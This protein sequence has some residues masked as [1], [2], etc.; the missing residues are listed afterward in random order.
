VPLLAG[1][2]L[3]LYAGKMG[4]KVTGISPQAMEALVCHRWMGNV[5]ELE[6][7]IERAVVLTS[8]EVVEVEDLPQ[9]LRE[10]QGGGGDI[11]VLSLAHLPYAEA[12]RLAMRA[13]ERRYLSA[14]LEKSGH[15]VSSAA[16]AAGVD[17]SNFRRLLK[18]YEVVRGPLQQPL[19]KPKPEPMSA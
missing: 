6:N 19:Q 15:N 12:K 14:L 3:R 13:F 5:R 18:Q 16:R 4:K 11:E 10:S 8:R 2:F 1:H 7:V 17:R 9:Q